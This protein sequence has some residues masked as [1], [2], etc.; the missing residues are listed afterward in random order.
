MMLYHYDKYVN[1]ASEN[2]PR[3]I[4]ALRKIDPAITEN[5]DKLAH[6]KNIK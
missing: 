2:W 1:S 4:D 5:A 3:A 6:K